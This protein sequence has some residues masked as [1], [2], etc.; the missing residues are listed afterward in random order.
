M[1]GIFC[2][3]WMNGNF[4][5]EAVACAL[6]S[7]EQ[8]VAR[9]KPTRQELYQ[10]D[11]AIIQNAHQSTERLMKCNLIKKAPSEDELLNRLGKS[12]FC[13]SFREWRKLFKSS[14]RT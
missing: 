6:K 5:R 3:K 7:I 10:R 13:G 2:Q 1:N 14:K 11:S 8:G 12:C 4:P 9:V